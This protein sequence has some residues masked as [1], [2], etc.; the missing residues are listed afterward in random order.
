M[1]LF[2]V[3]TNEKGE[4]FNSVV[5]NID[6]QVFYNNELIQSAVLRSDVEEFL[7]GEELGV[8]HIH[9]FQQ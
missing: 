7:R 4:N 3:L 2:S 9:V 8:S 5:I 1:E 6:P